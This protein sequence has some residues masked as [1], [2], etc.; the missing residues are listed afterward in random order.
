MTEEEKKHQKELWKQ[1]RARERREEWEKIRALGAGA[2][3]QYF[4]DYYKI[5]LVIV[6][7]AVL[8]LYFILNVIKGVRTDTLLYVC[9]LNSNELDPDTELLRE[10]YIQAR[11]GLENMQEMT[12]DSSLYVNPDANGTSQ[13]DVATSMKIAAF[14][15]AGTVDAFIAPPYVT[16]FE[17]KSGMYMAL[18][19]I[20]TQDEIQKLGSQNCLYYAPEPVDEDESAKNGPWTPETEDK[21]ADEHKSGLPGSEDVSAGENKS[22]LRNDAGSTEGADTAARADAF[23]LNTEAGDDKHIYAVR[24]D[25]A[26][27]FGNY[28][29]YSDTPVWFAVIGNAPH[30][31]ETLRFLHFLLGKKEENNNE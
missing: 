21:S 27:V 24:V 26:G 5:V 17:Q 28:H 1:D 8:A 23:V 14:V 4:W 7:G 16:D 22:D 2:R 13:A 18:D 6:L 25:Q 20:L 31:D 29:I 30:I 3:L 11:G 10:D 12:F 15:G 9:V 19:D